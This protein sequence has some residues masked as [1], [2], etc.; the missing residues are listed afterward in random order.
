MDI[1]VVITI[2]GVL[3]ALV[4][5]FKQI[6]GGEEGIQKE[7]QMRADPGL[8]PQPEKER[9]GKSGEIQTKYAV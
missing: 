8:N 2:I 9:Y 3:V 4:Q 1:S 7:T 6:K 5:R